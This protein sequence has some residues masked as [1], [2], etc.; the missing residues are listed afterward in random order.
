MRENF[1]RQ[2]EQMGIERERIEIH[3][4]KSPVE[5]LQLY[6]NI[7]IALDTYPYNG[8]LTTLEALWMGV[9]VISLFGKRVFLSRAGLSILSRIGMEFL[10]GSTPDEFVAK[11][12]ALATRQDALAKI[13]ASMRIRM[14][15]STLCD[16]KRFAREVEQAYRQMWRRWCQSQRATP[17]NEQPDLVG[18]QSN[19]NPTIRS[20]IAANSLEKA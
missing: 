6:S 10:A 17:P 15:A 20:R 8:C 9:P 5:H 4:W 16:A 13:R 18:R 14:A 12:T 19:D 3:G 7:D 2:F 11:A 1:F